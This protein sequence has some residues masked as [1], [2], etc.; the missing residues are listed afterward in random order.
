[1][2]AKNQIASLEMTLSA[3][4]QFDKPTPLTKFYQTDAVNQIESFTGKPA[5]GVTA[6]FHGDLE[7]SED[8]WFRLLFDMASTNNPT[9]WN[10]RYMKRYSG[11]ESTEG[12]EIVKQAE[13]YIKKVVENDV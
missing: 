10:M 2:N 13:E 1:M 11:P 7:P 6:Q 5:K 3:R 8:G 9:V 4:I 12:Q